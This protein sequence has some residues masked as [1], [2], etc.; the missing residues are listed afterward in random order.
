MLDRLSQPESW[1]EFL[2]Y[3]RSLVC[4]RASI[5]EIEDFVSNKEY[6]PICQSIKNGEPFPLPRRSE[7]NKT[8]TGKKRVIYTYP[9]RETMLLKL[10][11]FFL[12]REYDGI[13]SDGLFSFRPDKNAKDAVRMLLSTPG[14]EGM[15]SYKADISNYFNSINIPLLIPMLHKVM[16]DDPE[17]SDFLTKLLEEPHAVDSG[18]II[19][20]QK[21]IMA[22][23]PI[24]SFYANLF[25]SGLDRKFAELCVPYARYSDDIIVFAPD[26]KSIEMYADIIRG[27]ISKM[28]LKINPEKE[29][30]SSPEDGW[31]FLGFCFKD[32]KTDISPVTIH[33]LKA[34]MRR[35]TRALKRW[36]KRRGV[37]GENAAKAF[38][39]IFNR[40]LMDSPEDNELSWSFWFFSVINSTEGLKA[41]DRYSQE[42]IRYLISDSRTK[43]RFNVRYEKIKALGYKSL[44]HEYYSQNLR[45]K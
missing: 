37:T 6:I 29:L 5:S 39:R 28:E 16:S 35:K 4:S 42:C 43:S 3:R 18:K 45:M 21:G 14:I 23:T 33:K 41:I 12:L 26:K 15:Y 7:V 8:S 9:R 24:S 10:L 20:E 22:G 40:K 30:F 31:T 38:I 34:K 13:F 44:V 32:G 27:Y 17:L 25:L 36:Q 1:Q 11:T 19:T 2:E